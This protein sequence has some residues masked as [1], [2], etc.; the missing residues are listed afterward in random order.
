[1][2]ALNKG[3]TP[4]TQLLNQ[5]LVVFIDDTTRWNPQNHDGS[6]G[7][8]TTLRYG[9]KKSLNLISVRIVQELVSPRDVVKTAKL[10]N[11][12]TKIDAVP[13]IALGVSDV[14]PI[15]ITSAYSAFSNYGIYN[16][17]LSC[18]SL[19]TPLFELDVVFFFSLNSPDIYRIKFPSIYLNLSSSI[20][21]VG[22]FSFI[23]R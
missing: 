10:F 12:S 15:E 5:P 8:L 19:K 6:T 20:L 1:M 11:L 2:A 3:Y 16:S 4:R 13:A 21:I 9:L 14:I 22:C 23:K 18:H 7:L 17:P